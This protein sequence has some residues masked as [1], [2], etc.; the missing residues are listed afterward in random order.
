MKATKK[1]AKRVPKNLFKGIDTNLLVK[2]ATGKI[3]LVDMVYE[4][5]E[6]RGLTNSQARQ[7]GW[8]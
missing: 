8:I 5:L 1:A 4:E 3:D 2:I 6:N 7:V